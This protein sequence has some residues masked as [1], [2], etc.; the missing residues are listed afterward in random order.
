MAV[1]VVAMAAK[2]R[3]LVGDL[4]AAGQVLGN[5]GSRYAGFDGPKR[6]ADLGRSVRFEVPHVDM[7]GTALQEEE[8]TGLS[9]SGLRRGRAG[10]QIKQP[11]QAEPANQP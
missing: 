5:E 7:A 2:N 3:E 10:L 1:V 6:P 4:G 9:L 8:D 11:R